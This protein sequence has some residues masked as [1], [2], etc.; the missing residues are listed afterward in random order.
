M[1]ST[2][3]RKPGGLGAAARRIGL[4]VL[5][6]VAGV[7][8][9]F[10]LWCQRGKVEARRLAKHGLWTEARGAAGR[11]LLLHPRDASA[12]L[13]FAEALAKDESV[14][15]AERV[16][17]AVA[18]L[19]AVPDTSPEAGAARKA[20]AR[21]L[22]F[23]GRDAFSAER[24]LERALRIDPDDVEART[25]AWKILDL[26]RRNEDAEPQFRTVLAGTPVAERGK[27]LRDWY[28]SQFYPVTSTMDL[29]GLMGFRISPADDA[30]A[31]ESNRLVGFRGADPDSA[32]ANAAMARWFQSKG[33]LRFA[34]ELL[35]GALVARPEE[36]GKDPFFLGT[37]VDVLIDLGEMDR[38]GE[39]FAG[40]PE[41]DRSRAHWLAT[42]RVEQEVRDRPAEAAAAYEEALKVWP[43]PIDWRSMHRAATCQAR[44]G[45]GERAAELRARAGE[46]E[47]LMDEKA[48]AGLR[49][50]LVR[51]DNR[52]ELRQLV[53]FYRKIERP[54]EA[55]AWGAFIESLPDVAPDTTNERRGS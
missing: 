20:E 31:V 15:V 18:S 38:A 37:L 41:G 11:Y 51:L 30:T 54:V 46:L 52:E 23:L 9:M 28:L 45:N 4:V 10:G 32:P 39:V 35:D 43:G 21:V 44:A 49:K 6:L 53:D 26:T 1:T 19:R 2:E 17:G 13:L 14:A 7:A 24:A 29:D 40:W 22:L 3:D 12:N 50:A 42:G 25:L 47:G 8:V 55:E 36:A 48:H 5:A 27:V 34:L 33:D 16:D